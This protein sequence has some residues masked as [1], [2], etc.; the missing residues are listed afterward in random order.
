MLSVPIKALADYQEL[1]RISD[2]EYDDA[3]S[4]LHARLYYDA[5]Q[6]SITHSDQ[7]RA[8]IFVKR[9]YEA[10]VICEG[11]DSPETQNMKRLMKHPGAHRNMGISKR[12]EMTTAMV[13]KD[14][15]ADRFDLWLWRQ[16]D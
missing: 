12:W 11:E 16:P 13:P 9:A 4:P 3:A 7:A 1:T 6:I 15:D 5:F 14:L 2:D 10:R 8:S